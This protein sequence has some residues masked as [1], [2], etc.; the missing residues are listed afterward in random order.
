V[1]DESWFTLRA[2]AKDPKDDQRSNYPRV[3]VEYSIARPSARSASLSDTYSLVARACRS[4]R[5]DQP[6]AGFS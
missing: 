5:C 3:D 6:L 2:I 4:L 1:S